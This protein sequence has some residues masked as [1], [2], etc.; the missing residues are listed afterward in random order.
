MRLH[1]YI[2]FVLILILLGAAA[3][4]IFWNSRHVETRN[5]EYYCPMHPQIVRTDPGSCPICGMTLIEREKNPPTGDGKKSKSEQTDHQGMNMPGMDMDSMAPQDMGISPAV[6]E[7]AA[8]IIPGELQ[9]RIGVKIG[10]V[11][12]GPLKMSVQR[13]GLFSPTKRELPG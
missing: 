2:W 13:W 7:H 9:Q 10:R 8:V 3:Y 4:F 11:E 12:K 6:P 1:L 5:I